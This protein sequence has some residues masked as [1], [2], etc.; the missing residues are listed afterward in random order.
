MPATI[1]GLP[2][3]GT[4][5]TRLGKLE[6]TNGYPT[7]A[8]TKKLYDDLDFQRACQAFL[9][10]LPAVGFH[11]VHRAHLHIFGAKDGDVVLYKDLKD[12][13]G[14][15]TPNITTFYAMSFWNLDTQG[16]LVVDV[17]ADLTAGGIFDCWQRPISDTGQTGPDKGQGAKYLVLGP[18]NGDVKADGFLVVR[19]PA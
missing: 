11:G 13:A 16:P 10:A 17:P 19:S 15:L 2:E 6:L 18:N 7:L 5:D 14:M 12:K 9:W 3:T 1:Q 4:V 8:T